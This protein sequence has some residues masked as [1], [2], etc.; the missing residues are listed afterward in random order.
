MLGFSHLIPMRKQPLFAL[1]LTALAAAVVSTGVYAQS[2][3]T[4][5]QQLQRVEITGSNIKRISTET[6][7][8]VQIISRTQIEAS[9]NTTLKGL[10]DELSVSTGG[11]RDIESSNR[12]SP[13]ASAIEFRNLGAQA[14]LVLLN[15]RRLAP[16]GLADYATLFT[17]VDA[18]PIDAIERVEILK[19]G[20]SA[21][22]GSDAIAGVINI[23]TRRDYKGLQLQAYYGDSSNRSVFG[24]KGGS[25]LA[26][27][28]DITQDRFNVFGMVS[29][30]KRDPLMYS[31]IISD[32]PEELTQYSPSYGTPSTFSYPG[33]IIGQGSLAGCSTK[34]AAGLCVY[35]RY[36][37]F[38]AIPNNERVN[39]TGSFRFAV[40]Q[41]TEFFADLLMARN[42][43]DFL[44]P[45]GIYGGP[46]QGTTTWG[47]PQTNRAKVFRYVNLPA[48]HPLNTLGREAEF[49]YRFVDAGTGQEV[50]S[51]D[52]RLVAGLKGSIKTYDWEASIASLGSKV[53][54]LQRGSFSDSGFK[55][56]IG[57]YN[58]PGAD[59]FNKPNGYK[60]GQANSEAVLS[61]LFPKYGYSGETKQIV[62]DAKLSG[63]V[64]QMAAGP[65][66]M[67][68]GGEA[69]REEHVIDPTA[70]LRNGDIVGNGLSATSAS[71]T[72]YAGYTEFSV[73]VLKTL[74][75]QV[76][77]R[78]DKFPGFSAHFSPKVAMRYQPSKELLLRG[79]VDSGFRAPNLT[80]SAESTKFAFQA[81]NDPKR[82]PQARQLQTALRAQAAPLPNTDPNKALLLARADSV[83]TAECGS[84]AL[85]TYNNPN[86]KPETSRSVSAGMV[87]EPVTGFSVAV[88]YWNIERKDEISA[89]SGSRLLS[90]E[91]AGSPNIQRDALALDGTFTA[92]ERAQ[93]GVTA[94]KLNAIT[95][96][97]VNLNRT[98]TD[99]VDLEIKFRGDT[100][101]GKFGVDFTSTYLSNYKTWNT[102]TNEWN[103]NYAGGYT[104]PRI[105]SSLRFSLRMPKW[106]HGLSF[107]G[108]SPTSISYNADED[109]CGD[110]GLEPQHCRIQG[111]TRTDYYVSYTGFKD[112]SLSL[113]AFNIFN[114]QQ[115]T[116]VRGFLE[117][118]SGIIPQNFEDSRR[119]F[120]RV[121]ATYR[122]K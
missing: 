75:L 49:R 16:Y 103:K 91:G 68:V 58:N 87:F 119:G 44:S 112:L 31:T 94:G 104:T 55:E 42:K 2:T 84:V 64:M 57:D 116:N 113:N 9:G 19:S 56:M 117:D 78:V 53:D 97:F 7:V 60:I 22:Y 118:G 30:Y 71:R 89:R 54:A 26:G 65:L 63:E 96:N 66:G 99:G 50:E 32:T 14:T 41:D 111:A 5:P 51:T 23:I 106:A 36:E 35:D 25:V 24:E 73:P 34:N 76:A 67:A 90:E 93:Y 88:D 47:D 18:L 82:C 95:R 59:F 38:Q 61:R 107:T 114:K 29:F 15:G 80:E 110:W 83:V 3:D 108:Y 45:H 33:N 27:M 12:F 98:K 8:P 79:T 86:L 20:A 120:Y 4:Q 72:S 115:P 121:T 11:L 39:F 17:N 28:G 21:I 48:T 77:G 43:V 1:R 40:S 101:L 92:E 102:T 85:I 105:R 122:F 81:A 13:G 6:A 10:I 109:I 52:Y 69:R 100:A 62:L 46:N 37:R 70:N 74:E